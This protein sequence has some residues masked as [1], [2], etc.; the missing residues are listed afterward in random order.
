M[1]IEAFRRIEARKHDKAE[2]Q[3]IVRMYQDKLNEA[4][5]LLHD[6]ISK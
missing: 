5:Q 2:E 4:S 6:L 3:L 1:K